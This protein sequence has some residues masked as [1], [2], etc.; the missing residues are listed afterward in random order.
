MKELNNIKYYSIS[1]LLGLSSS[2]LERISAWDARLFHKRDIISF[3]LN[4]V[5]QQDQAQ[6]E[7]EKV[8]DLWVRQVAPPNIL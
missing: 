8:F 7:L 1:D 2:Y 5:A 3:P 4:T 6:V